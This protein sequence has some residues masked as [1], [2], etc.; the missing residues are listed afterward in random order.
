MKVAHVSASRAGTHAWEII[1]TGQLH[2]DD[3]IDRFQRS[4]TNV[5]FPNFCAI[6]ILIRE[7]ATYTRGT[8]SWYTFY[9]GFFL[10]NIPTVEIDFTLA[11]IDLL[12]LA[13][14]AP[15]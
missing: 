12:V 9:E 7:R 5:A 2:A 10:S 6:A 15:N 13:I 8:V 11:Q 1:L 14:N 3:A 4:T